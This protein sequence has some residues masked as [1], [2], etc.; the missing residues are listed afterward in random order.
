MVEMEGKLNSARLTSAK[1]KS[2]N[3]IASTVDGIDYQIGL[4]EAEQ[5]YYRTMETIDDDRKMFGEV[6]FVGA[7]LGGGFTHTSELKPMKYE[8]AMAKDPIEWGKAVDKEH[9]KMERKVVFKETKRKDLPKD[10]KVC[11]TTWAM[12]QKASGDKR[13]RINVRGFEQVDGKHYDEHDK[14]APVASEI[15]IRVIVVLMLMAQCCG[16]LMDVLAFL[17][18]AFEPGHKMHIEF[19]KG[20]EKHYASV[21]VPPLLKTLCGTK[22]AAMQF[23]KLMCATFRKMGCVRCKADPCLFHNE[24]RLALLCGWR[25]WTTSQLLDPKPLSRKKSTSSKPSM[26]AMTSAN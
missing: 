4:S 8:E 16:H 5:N 18:G 22:Q 7:G 17:L 23:W 21:S 15:T 12:K 3:Y 14:A 10:A 11:S 6:C 26:N 24:P 20:F 9:D 2:G 25:G 13:A 19:P 1:P